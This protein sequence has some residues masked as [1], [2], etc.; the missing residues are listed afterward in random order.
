MCLMDIG[1]GGQ[2]QNLLPVQLALRRVLDI[3]YTSGRV[4]VTNVTDE[5]GQAVTFPSAPLR[6]Y[7]HGK[8]VLKEH[9][10]ELRIL[11]WQ[12]RLQP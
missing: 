5:S 10:L 7:Q 12:R 4:R 3:L 9:R 2:A 8:A 11:S 6:V 1:T